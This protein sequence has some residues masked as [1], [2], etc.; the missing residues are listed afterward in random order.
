VYVLITVIYCRSL[1]GARPPLPGAPPWKFHCDKTACSYTLTMP[2]CEGRP[3]ESCPKAAKGRGVISCQG[4]LWLCRECEEFRF[5]S[6]KS[7]N[8]GVSRPTAG[9]KLTRSSSSHSEATCQKSSTNSIQQPRNTHI[10]A[11]AVVKAKRVECAYH[12]FSYF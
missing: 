8:S 7:A 9:R 5:P 4:D 10:A 1:H 3:N 11:V 6:V 2:V 12:V